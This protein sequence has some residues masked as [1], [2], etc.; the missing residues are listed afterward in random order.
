MRDR[1]FMDVFTQSQRERLN[2]IDFRV[3]FTGQI[4]RADLM[5]RFGV[6]E[7]AAT[8]DL[9]AYQEAVPGNIEYDNVQKTYLITKK[10]KRHFLADT[11]GKHLLLALVH[12]MG[13]DFTTSYHPLIPCELPSRLHAP[14]IQN[15]AIV[16]R[17]IYNKQALKIDYVSS[18]TGEST[19]I[20]I[21]FSFAGNG[22]RWHVRAY[23]RRRDHFGDFVINRITKAE[24]LSNEQILEHELKENDIEWNRRVELEIVPHPELKQKKFVEVEHGMQDGIIRHKVRAAMA[25]YVLRLWNVDCTEDHSLDGGEYQLWLKNLEAVRNIES[26][27]MAPGFKKMELQ[28]S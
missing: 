2:Y 18:G 21:P 17:A 10:F 9:T 12:G 14:S 24:I 1:F 22:L 16:S 7:A 8:R 28:L 20:I 5:K 13:D 25:G 23:D 6:G 19:R 11:E 3:F 27:H 26:M 15:F 4:G